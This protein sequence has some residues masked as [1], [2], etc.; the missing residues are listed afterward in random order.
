MEKVVICIRY[1]PTEFEK[2]CDGE[3]RKVLQRVYDIDDCIV[4]DLEEQHEVNY[5]NLETVN[6]DFENANTPDQINYNF[7]K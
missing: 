3:E 6:F 7:P 4:D 2:E 5:G 1:H